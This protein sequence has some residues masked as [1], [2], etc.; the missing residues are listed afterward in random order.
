MGR[1]VSIT[2]RTRIRR[3][4]RRFLED[5]G[6]Q[7][8]AAGGHAVRRGRSRSLQCRLRIKKLYEKVDV[9]IQ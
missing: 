8:G 6:M 7:E 2:R 9:E 5:Q 1:A 3:R 4:R